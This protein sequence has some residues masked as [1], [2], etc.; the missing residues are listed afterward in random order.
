MAPQ[1]AFDRAFPE[2]AD[3]DIQVAETH[4][5]EPAGSRHFRKARTPP[6]G[7]H[8]PCR[9]PRC[10]HGG[11]SLGYFLSTM[12]G[13]RQTERTF[14]TSCRGEEAALKSGQRAYQPCPRQFEVRVKLT[15]HAPAAP[16][17]GDGA[18]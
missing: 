11:V 9:N 10:E 2:V 3:Y 13:S 15:Y 8:V 1:T 12:I 5:G 16:D 4:A 6:R 17:S 14:A 7:E 18:V